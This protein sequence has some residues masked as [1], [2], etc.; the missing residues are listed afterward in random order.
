MLGPLL[1]WGLRIE[2]GQI[3][4]ESAGARFGF[5]ANS[6]ARGLNEAEVFSN[7]NL[8]WRWDLG[9]G[10]HLESR[11]DLTA[12]WLG[13]HNDHAFIGTAGPSLILG[14]R[15]FPIHLDLGVSPTL[16][17]S[18]EWEHVNVGSRFQF[19]THMGADWD[20]TSH[21]RVGY[22]FVHMS[23]AGVARPNPGLNLHQVGVSYLF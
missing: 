5:G 22:R 8:P 9:A 21:F 12:G 19:A 18:H 10:L 11:F 23:N 20:I 7:F 6:I 17:S 3:D 13:I 16:L 15:Q 4:L 2:A 14:Y 1:C